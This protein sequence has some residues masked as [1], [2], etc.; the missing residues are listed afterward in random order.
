MNVP[1]IGAQPPQPRPA[2]LAD[3]FRQ[4]MKL[5]EQATM[6]RAAKAAPNGRVALKEAH[7]VVCEVPFAELE[8]EARE[9]ER[10]AMGAFGELVKAVMMPELQAFAGAVSDGLAAVRQE[11]REARER[12]APE[13]RVVDSMGKRFK[14]HGH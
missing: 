4:V 7:G 6:L 12:P 11:A 10:A 9:L 14:P 3:V 5:M 1:I 2:T 8:A 13:T